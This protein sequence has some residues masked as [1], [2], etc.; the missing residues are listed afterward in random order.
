[1]EH[2][3]QQAGKRGR[4]LFQSGYK[5]AESVLLSI[6]EQQ[7]IE[8]EIIPGIASGF[9]SGMARTGGMCGA[10]SGAVMGLGLVYGRKNARDPQ[11]VI[12]PLVQ[13]FMHT[14]EDRHGSICCAELINCDLNTRDGQTYY[15]ENHLMEKCY[16]L[17]EDAT[18]LALEISA[19]YAQGKLS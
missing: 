2:D 16:G 10:V 9:C 7:G 18:N 1:M 11:D 6:A 19:D 17:V 14:F 15:A 12:Y 8:A 3:M 13:R 4:M 5:C